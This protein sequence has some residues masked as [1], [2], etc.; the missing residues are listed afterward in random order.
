M[1]VRLLLGFALAAAA[2]VAAV[3]APTAGAD[4]VTGDPTHTWFEG[5]EID[6]SKS[7]G[8]ANA[9]MVFDDHTE[10]FRTEAEMLEAYTDEPRAATQDSRSSAKAEVGFSVQSTC[11]TTLRLYRLTGYGG[12][13][14]MLA[15]RGVFTNLSNYAF[16]N[17]T[18]SYRVGAC[19]STFYAGTGGGGSV[20]G[21]NT[22]AN[23]VSASMLSGWDNTVSSVY[24]S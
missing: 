18:S 15:T 8:E 17:D 20:Y 9:C 5:A 11:S 4:P 3:N 7:W 16:D 2:S 12:Q 19:S 22:W 24:I 23:A 10:C 1:R 13:V 6:L 14:L 21:G